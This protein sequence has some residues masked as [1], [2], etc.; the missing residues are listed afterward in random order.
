[1]PEYT[2]HQHI[3]WMCR[4]WCGDGML[5]GAA[6]A[7][8]GCRAF[9]LLYAC[10]SYFSVWSQNRVEFYVK[11]AGSLPLFPSSFL[12]FIFSVFIFFFFSFLYLSPFFSFFSPLFFFQASQGWH[13]L[14]TRIL[15]WLAGICSKTLSDF[16]HTWTFMCKSRVQYRGLLS[17]VFHHQ[18]ASKCTSDAAPMF[19]GVVCPRLFVGIS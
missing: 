18:R 7:W 13:L 2:H 8:K 9:F 12:S 15:L 11:I 1:M 19:L 14:E 5:S 16:P 6:K 3:G 10:V 17:S 4:N